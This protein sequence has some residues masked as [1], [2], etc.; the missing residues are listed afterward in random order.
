MAG[1]LHDIGKP[2][3][4]Q[5]EEVRHF[6][7]HPEVSYKMTKQILSRLNYDEEFIKRVAYLV[8]KHDTPIDVENLDNTYEMTQK[9]LKLQYADAKAHQI[10]LKVFC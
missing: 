2:F 8:R 1:L 6:H 10:V 3:S 4:F 9:L 7:G 5:D